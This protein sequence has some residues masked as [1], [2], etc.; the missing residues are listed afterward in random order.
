MPDTTDSYQYSYSIIIVMI[1]SKLPIVRNP[2]VR[3]ARRSGTS[4]EFETIMSKRQSEAVGSK[5]GNG[6]SGGWP[7]RAGK[8]Y[9]KSQE[10]V[11]SLDRQRFSAEPTNS[12]RTTAGNALA[13]APLDYTLD[14]DPID[15]CAIKGLSVLRHNVRK[16]PW[17]KKIILRFSFTSIGGSIVKCLDYTRELTLKWSSLQYLVDLSLKK[18][19]DLPMARCHDSLA[20]R[21]LGKLTNTLPGVLT[22]VFLH[23]GRMSPTTDFI[24]ATVCGYDASPL[25]VSLG[26]SASA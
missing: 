4:T 24:F 26:W 13:G 16:E 7:H 22:V 23:P 21:F 8:E 18:T 12:K 9:C 10:L 20:S 6:G 2:T 11:K 3:N 5:A 1:Y 25:L 17:A 14:N 19:F 15:Y